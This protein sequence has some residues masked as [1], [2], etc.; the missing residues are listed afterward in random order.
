MG[1]SHI[2]HGGAGLER[3]PGS[4][5]AQALQSWW[6]AGDTLVLWAPERFPSKG[7]SLSAL[8]VCSVPAGPETWAGLSVWPPSPGDSC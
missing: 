3:W 2:C 7:R 6:G 1:T 5:E 4:P 8:P